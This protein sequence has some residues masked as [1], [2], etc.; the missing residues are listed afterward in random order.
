[1]NL[2][3]EAIL[4]FFFS[5]YDFSE[6][7]YINAVTKGIILGFFIFL[8]ILSNIIIDPESELILLRLFYPFLVSIVGGVIITSLLYIIDYIFNDNI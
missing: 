5:K 1:M 3:L 7:K 8:L 6:K 4:S 2:I